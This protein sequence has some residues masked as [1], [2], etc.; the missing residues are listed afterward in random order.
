M[1]QIILTISALFILYILIDSAYLVITT[2]IENEKLKQYQK[3][4]KLRN[5]L[6]HEYYIPVSI[7]V[8]TYND[9]EKIL[10]T[11]D[12]ILKLNYKLYE[13]VIIDDGSKDQTRETLIQSFNLKKVNKPFRNILKTKK[14]KEIYHGTYK[15]KKITLVH[16]EHG[17]DA[18]AYNLGINASEYP[19]FIC[20]NA[21]YT[22]QKDTL[23]NLFRPILED[24][25]V[26]ACSGSIQ[27]GKIREEYGNTYRYYFPDG[28]LA[29]G[30]AIEYSKATF[31]TMQ[32]QENLAGLPSITLFRKDIVVSVLGFDPNGAGENFELIGKIKEASHIQQDH[33]LLKYAP[34]ATC[35]IEVPNKIT[36]FIKQREKLNKAL[37]A[38]YKKSKESNRVLENLFFLLY[39]LYAPIIKVI[40]FIAIVVACILNLLS[41]VNMIVFLGCYLLLKICLSTATFLAIEHPLHAKLKGSGIITVIYASIIEETVL[42]IITTTGKILGRVHKKV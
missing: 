41:P 3:G 11:I 8:K 31:L 6:K 40:G 34:N 13:I 23:E 19:Y 17:G 15:N 29:K 14:T 36:D 33:Y 39:K 30:Q 22:V 32:H 10:E 9:E 1:E 28:I 37:L 2:V 24:E 4:Q 20:L 26:V 12:S 25:K 5:R 27:V 21:N 18:D 16:K 42:K 7:I 35:L 38:N